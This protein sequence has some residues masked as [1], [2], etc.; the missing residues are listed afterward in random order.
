MWYLSS[1]TNNGYPYNTN[2]IGIISSVWTDGIHNIPTEWRIDTTG[3]TN[4]GYPYNYHMEI[5]LGG[6]GGGEEGD[7]DIMHTGGHTRPTR[8]Y[9]TVPQ[10]HMA[11]AHHDHKRT[12][13]SALS[14]KSALMVNGY[15]TNTGGI[16]QLRLDLNSFPTTH[17][18][19]MI[20]V[21]Q[22]Y[23]ANIFNAVVLAR[24][25]PFALAQNTDSHQQGVNS[26]NVKLAP[27]TD[28]YLLTNSTAIL[29]F[30]AVDLDISQG[31]EISKYTY[32]LYLPYSGIHSIDIRGNEEV[33]LI[34]YVDL[35]AGTIDYI[36][37]V[38]DQ[39]ELTAQG[40]IGLDIPFNVQQGEMLQNAIMNA[41]KYTAQPI[42]M[43]A[44]AGIG[45][46]ISADIE[47][48]KMGAEIGNKAGGWVGGQAAEMTVPLSSSNV[49]GG[50]SSADMYSQP[51]IIVK[52]QVMHI[53]GYGY[54]EELGFRH[55]AGVND[56]SRQKELIVVSNYKCGVDR[57][58]E[59]EKQEIIRLLENGVFM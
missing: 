9:T 32:K 29:D 20:A 53:E 11:T 14:T 21:S 38:N 6:G 37:Y 55:L 17:P 31:F 2:F 45:N 39:I 28:F 7:G 52:K 16:Q 22:I 24:V 35:F 44:G 19:D 23:G 1:S 13:R 48:V 8:S 27:D 15:I 26:M 57:A 30:G 33:Q 10:G 41:I 4:D 47:A 59:R 46:M 40:K 34:G 5:W 42:G 3:K 18:G 58:T 12:T 54:P 49:S 50:A 25:F 36:F 43:I 51:C 56:L